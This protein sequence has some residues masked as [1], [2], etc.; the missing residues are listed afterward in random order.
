MAGL[1][2]ITMGP[3]KTIKEKEEAKEANKEIVKKIEELTGLLKTLGGQPEPPLPSDAKWQYPKYGHGKVEKLSTKTSG[4]GKP[5]Q[6][7]PIWWEFCQNTG[8]TSRS[9][10]WVRMHLI[11]EK[12]GGGGQAENLIPAPNSVNTGAQVLHTF[13]EAAKYLVEQKKATKKGPVVQKSNVIWLD[14][15][16][17]NHRSSPPESAPADYNKDW[18]FKEVTMQGGLNYYDKDWVKDSAAR[19]KENVEIPAPDFEPEI[20]SLSKP[21]KSGLRG[22]H[23][24]LTESIYELI[25][26]EA[27]NGPFTSP[28]NFEDRMKARVNNEDTWKDLWVAD[29]IKAMR[30]KKGIIPTIND[31]VDKGNLNIDHINRQCV[32]SVIDKAN[33]LNLFHSKD[34]LWWGWGLA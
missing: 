15:E 7:K 26:D 29:R 5:P 18:F 21:S 2:V 25:H 24:L 32:T 1:K 9:D 12:V 10:G 27:L 8:L 14:V 31:L 6:G 19:F 20:Q 30:G 33:A 3:G 13:E 22:L 17:K 4:G 11:S 16:A 34:I 23:D 28:K